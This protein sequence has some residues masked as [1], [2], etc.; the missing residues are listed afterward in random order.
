MRFGNLP[1]S[2]GQGERDFIDSTINKNQY[3]RDTSRE[4]QDPSRDTFR[5]QFMRALALYIA[6][7]SQGLE[8]PNW[9]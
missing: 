8:N 4:F 5:I 7:E 3:K 9:I 2:S 6:I 1:T